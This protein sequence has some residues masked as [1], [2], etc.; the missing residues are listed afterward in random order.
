MLT[1]TKGLELKLWIT[2]PYR[3]YTKQKIAKL[4]YLILR[5][6][7]N[8]GTKNSP[9]QRP[10]NKEQVC[11]ILHYLQQGDIFGSVCMTFCLLSR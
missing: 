4:S 8:L 7:K 9:Q 2:N 6:S 10:A 11:F 5:I 1:K 3:T